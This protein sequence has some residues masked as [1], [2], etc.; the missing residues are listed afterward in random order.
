MWNILSQPFWDYQQII[1]YFQ[2]PVASLLINQIV[3]AK[4]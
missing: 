1:Q 4:V 2:K 3:Y